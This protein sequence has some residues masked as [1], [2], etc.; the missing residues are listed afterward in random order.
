[1]LSE[2]SWV[3]PAGGA[4]RDGADDEMML[5]GTACSRCENTDQNYV[6]KV[7]S[8]IDV[9]RIARSFVCLSRDKL[10]R[11]LHALQDIQG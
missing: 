6:K 1:M 11:L 5:A 9:I 7:S 2:P 10:G 4:A 8:D 3:D